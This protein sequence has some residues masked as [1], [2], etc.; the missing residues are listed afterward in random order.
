MDMQVV[1]KE[2]DI[3][4]IWSTRAIAPQLFRRLDQAKCV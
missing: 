1:E 4:S 3:I 2:D